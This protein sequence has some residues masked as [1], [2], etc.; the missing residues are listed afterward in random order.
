MRSESQSGQQMKSD[1]I[2]DVTQQDVD[3]V[4]S[5]HQVDWLIH[6]HTHRPHIHRWTQEGVARERW[7]LGDW[8]EQQGWCIDDTCGTFEL[9]SFNLSA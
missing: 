6:G 2:M 3:A 7:V 1:D 5:Q 8:S 4:M 9:R